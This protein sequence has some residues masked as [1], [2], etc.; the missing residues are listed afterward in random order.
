M[1][2]IRTSPRFWKTAAVVSVAG[3]VAGL[4]G[5]AY[6]AVPD[7][8]GVIHGCVKKNSGALRVIDPAAGEACTSAEN[9]LD[10]SQQGP[11]GTPGPAGPAG[12]A[13]AAGPA[14]PAGPAG[15]DGAAGP[16]GAPGVSGYQIVRAATAPSAA[17][18]QLGVA[19]CPAGKKAVGGGALPVLD[20]GISGIVDLVAVHAEFP[21]TVTNTND[22]W[23]VQAVET[24]PDN[25]TTW[26]LVV[27]AVCVTA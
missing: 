27:W 4:A 20:T 6:A 21:L 11:A 19:T 15:A 26:H 10:F 23:D 7:A 5:V 18:S 1:T 13:G 2:K 14:G 16:A 9:P 17:N 3:L 8:N 25:L 24:Q 22:S 12:A